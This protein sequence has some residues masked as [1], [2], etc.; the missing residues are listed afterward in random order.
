MERIYGWPS[1]TATC[2]WKS[3]KRSCR[4]HQESVYR[5]STGEKYGGLYSH[6]AFCDPTSVPKLPRLVSA[7]LSSLP[8][9]ASAPRALAHLSPNLLELN[10]LWDSLTSDLNSS[11][12]SSRCWEYINSLNLSS[13][14]SAA[15][16]KYTSIPE[17]QWLRE[18]GVVQ[19]VISCLP[20]A[21]SFWIKAGDKGVVHIHTSVNRPDHP[22]GSLVVR[23]GGKWLSVVH[24]PALDI[25]THEIVSTTGAGD[26]LVGS[27]A[28]GL[29]SLDKHTS[30]R[31]MVLDAMERAGQSIRSRR[32]VYGSGT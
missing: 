4:R 8:E 26:T 2:A 22:L 14:F 7:L 23:A 16:E 1:L 21:E 28:A 11:S 10:L 32:A 20:F 19:K 6:T 31:D 13:D 29:I 18:H 30:E 25:P 5:V 17:R 15:I 24:Y 27:L 3:S 12:V 9:E